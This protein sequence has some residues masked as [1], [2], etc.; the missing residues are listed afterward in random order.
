MKRL[1]GI[2]I[3][4]VTPLTEVDTV[5]VESLKRLTDYCIDGGMTTLYPCGK[6]RC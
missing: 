3:P 6:N 5:D 2:V 1:S 4:L